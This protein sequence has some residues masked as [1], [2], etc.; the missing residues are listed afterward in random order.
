MHNLWL[1]EG[2]C[3]K[4]DYSIRQFIWGGKSNMWVKWETITQPY[5]R[6]HLGIRGARPIN[7]SMLDKHV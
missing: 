4:I 1:L 3:S 7:V 2:I 6:G 5:T